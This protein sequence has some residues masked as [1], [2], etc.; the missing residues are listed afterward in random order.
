MG[1][2][3]HP[4]YGAMMVVDEGINH[5]LA[6]VLSATDYPNILGVGTESRGG[7]SLGY[8]SFHLRLHY[9]DAKLSNLRTSPTG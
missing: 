4:E 1:D 6:V 3:L 5:G 7:L 8:L 2:D 9:G